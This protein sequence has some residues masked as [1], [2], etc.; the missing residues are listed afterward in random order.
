MDSQSFIEYADH[1]GKIIIADAIFQS[2]RTLYE[3]LITEKK[4][5]GQEKSKVVD[6][7]VA[8]QYATNKSRNFINNV[9]YESNDELEKLWFDAFKKVVV[10]KIDENL[11]DYLSNKAKFWGNPQAWLNNPDTLVLIPKLNFLNDQCDMLLMKL[12][13]KKHY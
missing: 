2:L 9:D 4:L 7:I 11:P 6:A 12:K 5:S 8:I 13:P 10:A 1:V 3:S